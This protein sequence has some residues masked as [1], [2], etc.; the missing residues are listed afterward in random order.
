MNA[1]T[2]QLLDRIRQIE[3]ELELEL[4]RRRTELHADFENRRIRFEQ[5]VLE[6]QRRFK[7]G[8]MLMC[9]P[10]AGATWCRRPLFTRCSFH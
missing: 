8:L 9:W 3:D 2:T 5:E 4:K 6:Q 1:T 7:M 10:P